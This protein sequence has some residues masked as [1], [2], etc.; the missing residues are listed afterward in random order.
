[1]LVYH[2]TK[3]WHTAHALPCGVSQPQAHSWMQHVLP[4]LRDTLDAL[5]MKPERAARRGAHHPLALA[6]GPAVALDGTERR[7]QR[8]ADATK[9]KEHD[10]G[11]TKTPTDKNLLLVNEQTGKV[12]SLSPTVAG[13]RHDKKMADEAAIA[14][15]ANAPLAKETGVQGSEPEGVLSRQSQ[16]NRQ[17]RH[18][19]LRTSSSTASSPVD[20]SWSSM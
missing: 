11:K 18:G 19:G 20:A 6:G 3:P 1:M 16:K 8:P 14:Y 10:S 12:V 7:R 2:K 15:P 17:A 4:S 5:G 9:H 13:T